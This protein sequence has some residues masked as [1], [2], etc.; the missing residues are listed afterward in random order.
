MAVS[1]CPADRVEAPVEVVWDLL[2]HPAGYGRFLDLVL[3]RVEPAG[4]AAPGQRFAGW[5]RSWCRRWRVEGEVVEA[6]AGRHQIRF[7]TS[8]PFGI[9]G[10]NRVSC[11]PRKAS[12]CLVR[13]G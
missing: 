12:T 11:T 5:T 8:L 10:D 7:R 6:D 3:E 13:F 4:P 2:A 9:V 1:V